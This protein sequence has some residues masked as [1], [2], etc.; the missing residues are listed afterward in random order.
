MLNIWKDEPIE[1][2]HYDFTKYKWHAHTLDKVKSE[3]IKEYPKATFVEAR[4]T[5]VLPRVCYRHIATFKTSNV[6]L[7][8]ESIWYYHLIE[9]YDCEQF[10]LDQRSFECLGLKPN[11]V[12]VLGDDKINT[13]KNYRIDGG[14]LRNT[15]TR[16]FGYNTVHY[17]GRDITSSE[18]HFNISE[19][20]LQAVYAK[21]TMIGQEVVIP[22][23][24]TI[25]FYNKAK[26]NFVIYSMQSGLYWD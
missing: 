9:R 8:M 7:S 1:V 25:V 24:N 20:E 5:W 12:T 2:K 4:R 6:G 15:L 22:D 23:I 21:L 10:I 17:G 18:M 13:I 11:A 14:T 19:D 16:I 3:I 26:K